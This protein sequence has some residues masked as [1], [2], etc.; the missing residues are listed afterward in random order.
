MAHSIRLSALNSQ[1]RCGRCIR[2]RQSAL[3][4]DISQGRIT[5]MMVGPN[6]K[7]PI[8]IKV[9][10]FFLVPAAG[11]PKSE[12]AKAGQPPRILSL[13]EQQKMR[14]VCRVSSVSSGQTHKPRCLPVLPSFLAPI[15]LIPSIC[16]CQLAREVLDIA[17]A[18]IRPGVTT[19]AIDAIVHEAIIERN[20]YPSPLNYRNFPKSVCTCVFG[21]AVIWCPH[22]DVKFFCASSV[23]E[24]ICHGIPDQRKL[25]EGD[26]INIGMAFVTPSVYS[27]DRKQM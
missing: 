4:L 16:T 14:T 17:A 22:L 10:S 25:Q 5:R 26:I 24:V 3:Y 21:V 11:T 18:A 20:A 13:E 15:E 19:D 12:I 2:L 23:N 6:Q 7:P 9:H 8:G 27:T 1:D